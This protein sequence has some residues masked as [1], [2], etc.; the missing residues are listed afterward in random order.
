MHTLL[1]IRGQF[2]TFFPRIQKPTRV[3]Q[4]SYCSEVAY[5]NTFY[6]LCVCECGWHSIIVVVVLWSTLVQSV[7]GRDLL[8]C[9]LA[10]K[11]HPL[12]SEQQYTRE[13]QYLL[14]GSNHIHTACRSSTCKEGVYYV[15]LTVSAMISATVGRGS[16][17][18]PQQRI[19]DG[20]LNCCSH[21]Q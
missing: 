21:P 19:S 14:F 8:R 2:S 10:S 13:V 17:C 4:H 7:L 5:N 11:L 15:W 20:I 18:Q 3:T 1:L 12:I 16:A 6:G 9:T